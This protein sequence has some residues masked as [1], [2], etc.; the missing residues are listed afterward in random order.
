M[1]SVMAVGQ[2]EI[3]AHMISRG[4][5]RMHEHSAAQVPQRGHD[6]TNLANA[7]TP[8]F[9]NLLTVMITS[10]ACGR[11]RNACSGAALAALT[12]LAFIA[13]FAYAARQLQRPELRFDRPRRQAGGPAASGVERRSALRRA[14][15]CM[16]LVVSGL[17]RRLCIHCICLACICCGCQS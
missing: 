7:C 13:P 2:L 10:M 9:V 8:A 6:V 1:F 15:Q 11:S 14:A 12:I 17:H 5:C 3:P 16:C 4:L